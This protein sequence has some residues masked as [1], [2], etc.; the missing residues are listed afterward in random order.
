MGEVRSGTRS[1]STDEIRVRAAK[2]ASGLAAMG[3]G[4]GDCV[5]IYMRNDIAFF[6]A[7]FAANLIGAYPV[8]VNWHYTRSEARYIFENSSSKAIII[9]ADLARAVAESFPPN[10]PILVVP[11]PPEIREA[12]H[13]PSEFCEV[14]EG[15][16]SW[17]E[18]LSCFPPASPADFDPPGAMIYTSGTTGKPK[19][20]RR[21]PPTS[22]QAR[23]A[24]GIWMRGFGFDLDDPAN[25]V[26]VVTGP[27]YHS[28]PNSYG[29][30]AARLGG[31][32]ILQPRFDAEDLLRLVGQYKV[33]HLHLVP[34]MLNR[35]LRLSESARNNYDISSL[36]FAVHSAAPVSPSIKR[37]MIEWWGP[38]IAEYYGTT[39]TSMLTFCTAGEW[40]NHP[41]TVGRPFAETRLLILDAAGHQIACGETGEITARAMQSADFTYHGDDAKRRECEKT[42]LFVTGD[43]GFFDADGFLY[44][45][46]RAKDMIISGGVNIY[47]AEIESELHKMPGVADCAVFGVPDDEYGEAVCAIVQLQPDA[48]IE[49]DDIRTYLRRSVAGYKLP[50]L[51]EF[52]DNLP[53]EDSGK[54]FKRKLR[55]PYWSNSD[56]KI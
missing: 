14:E 17:E 21:L 26:T 5:A 9:H 53:R 36:K 23:A 49:R 54:I 42:G 29:I 2:A 1:V 50:R 45:C 40:L 25:I 24:T 32:V 18:W 28:A 55:E 3:I 30:L 43:I 51:I 31:T 46:D 38:I 56:R 37:A 22:A 27:M 35:M 11:T 8:P 39:E 7:T 10:V 16:T 33:T 44:L 47:P 52:S 12:Y 20:V 48:V 13:I 6:E 34:I 41:G 4:F 15:M 19:G